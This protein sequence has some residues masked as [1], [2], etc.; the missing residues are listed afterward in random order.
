MVNI[1][2]QEKLAFGELVCFL[3]NPSLLF[4][5]MGD[6]PLSWSLPGPERTLSLGLAAPGC[7]SYAPAPVTSI[8]KKQKNKN[9]PRCR[10][11]WNTERPLRQQLLSKEKPTT[12]ASS[13]AAV[14]LQH[15]F[16]ITV[17]FLHPEHLPTGGTGENAVPPQRQ[18]N[19]PP[20]PQTLWDA[21]YPNPVLP[22]ANLGYVSWFLCCQTLPS[23]SSQ[24]GE[25]PFSSF[26]LI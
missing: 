15:T 7:I 25:I 26:C 21:P 20:A 3:E 13:L 18:L 2:W 5:V 24:S 8:K 19:E 9:S 11:P 17:C 12:G 16:E 10:A 6:S 14:T 1:H 23:T 4:L 22:K